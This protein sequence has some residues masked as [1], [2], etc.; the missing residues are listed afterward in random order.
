[1]Q[2]SGTVILTCAGIGSRLGLGQTKV[3]MDFGGIS[4]LGIHLKNFEQVKDLRIVVGY[5]ANDVVQEALKYRTDIVFVYNHEY[6]ETKTAYSLWLGTQYAEK[7][8]I[9]WDGDLLVHPND[10][11]KCLDSSLSEYLGYS[12][13]S[14]QDAVLLEV[15][16][17]MVTSFAGCAGNDAGGGNA[18][19]DAK[20]TN[21]FEWT[22]PYCLAKTR[23]AKT[24]GNVC[25]MLVKSL[26]LPGLKVRAQ[27]IDT[28]DD[29]CNAKRKVEEW[30]K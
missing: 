16:G 4:L 12:E 8:V 21:L 22:G 7:K 20:N 28:Y 27:D 2:F 13:S 24:K 1:M 3:L 5:Q 19:R 18:V 17:G 10:V 6:F 11:E 29:Y 30:Y 15:E 14:S 26:P 9:G 23:I 25:D